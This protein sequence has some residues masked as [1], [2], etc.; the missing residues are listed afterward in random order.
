[1]LGSLKSVVMYISHPFTNLLIMS[2]LSDSIRCWKNFYFQAGAL[3]L[4]FSTCYY[5]CY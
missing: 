1:M 2:G 3:Q 4:I 5:Q